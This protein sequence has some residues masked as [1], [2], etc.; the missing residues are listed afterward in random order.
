M[1]ATFGSIKEFDGNKEEWLQYV[2][3]LGHYFE[4]ICTSST[5]SNVVI[6]ELRTMF[7]KFGLPETV[8]TDN[9]TGFTSHEFNSF[10][11]QNGIKHITSAP[12]HPSSNGLAERAVQKD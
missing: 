6:E 12:Y 4:A 7:A 1:A 11:K 8:V 2:E 9:G 5:S 10:L 3:R